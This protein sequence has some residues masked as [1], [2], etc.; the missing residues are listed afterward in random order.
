MNVFPFH[1]ENHKRA[2]EALPKRGES[3]GA[4]EDMDMAPR[5]DRESE[6]RACQRVARVTVAAFQAA[7]QA[8]K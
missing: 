6:W 4:S 8:G 1:G 7:Q 5:E 2:S 3:N